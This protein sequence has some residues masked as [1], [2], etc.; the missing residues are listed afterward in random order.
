[1]KRF[2]LLTALLVLAFSVSAWAVPTGTSDTDTVQVT[3]T[4][5]T[6]MAID[7]TGDPVAFG[8]L[9]E[10][11]L[12]ATYATVTV[13]DDLDAWANV[14]KNI[15]ADITTAFANGY[16]LEYSDGTN[17]YDVD[18][19]AQHSVTAASPFHLDITSWK[20]TGLLWSDP[21]GADQA[22]VTFTIY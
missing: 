7:Y 16:G 9:T 5:P 13:D 14:G 10:A 21:P 4:I 3:C 6:F 22:T 17:D 8:T 18:G 20:V 2:I 19:T 12:L 11:D 15:K 1:M